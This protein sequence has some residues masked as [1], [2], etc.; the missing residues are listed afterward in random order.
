M[1]ISNTTNTSDSSTTFSSTVGTTTLLSTTT[2][3]FSKNDTIYDIIKTYLNLSEL[4]QHQV[5]DLM[6]PEKIP[7]R[8]I[9]IL[10]WV[11]TALTYLLAIPVVVRMVRSKF[12]QNLTDY[13]SFHII[14]C[15]FIAWIP[16]LI[17]I[18]YYWSQLLTLKL[19]RL[20]YV[21]LSTNET[22]SFTDVWK[23][24]ICPIGI[25]FRSR[26]SLFFI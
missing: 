15:A 10:I 21:V 25:C 5:A 23:N 14:M 7:L 19:C 8:G 3:T 2:R 4:Y 16:T 24:N 18:F 17:F 11:L 22:V 26:C 13:F 6:E 12:Y 9:H 20:H 1:N